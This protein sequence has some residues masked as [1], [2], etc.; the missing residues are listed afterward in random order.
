MNK[1]ISPCLTCYKRTGECH[2]KCD[3]YEFFCFENE[4]YRDFMRKQK[5]S[6]DVKYSDAR[7]KRMRSERK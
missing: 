2:G 3:T 6:E 1:P 5:H 4:V 7:V